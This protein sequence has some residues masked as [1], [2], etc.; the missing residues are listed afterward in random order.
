MPKNQHNNPPHAEL[1]T[2]AEVRLQQQ[3]ISPA[4][5]KQD[6][7]EEMIRLIHELEVHHVELEMQQEELAHKRIEL[8]ESLDKYTELYDFAPT[9]YLT[10]GRDSTILQSNLTA[11]KLL[12]VD[13]SSLEGMQLKRFVVPGDYR[14]IEDLLETVFTKRVPRNCELKLL[15]VALQPSSNEYPAL[16]GRTLRLDAVISETSYMCKVILTDI[17]ER[18]YAETA[19]KNSEERFRVMFEKHSAIKLVIDPET[20]NI[21]NANQAAADIYGWSVEKLCTMKIQDINTLSP[22]QVKCEME[23]SR[24]SEKKQF[25]FQHRQA[26]GSILD[27]EV[28]SNPI[29]IEGKILLYSIIHDITDRKR[30]AEES[31]RLKSA[32]LANISHEIRTPMNGI[33]GFSELLKDADLTGEEQAEYIDL[34][35]QSGHRML[36]LINDLMDI[37]KIDAKET[38]LQLTQTPINNLLQQIE[39]SFRLE[40]KKGGLSLRCTTGLSDTESTITT[41]SVKLSL[42]MT[43]LIQNALKFTTKGGVDFGYTRKDDT[44]EFYCID[45]GIGIA[46]DHKEKIFDRFHQIDTS[47]TRNQEGSGLGLSIAKAYVEMLCGKLNVQSKEGA[48]SSFTFTLF[49]NP[50]NPPNPT[51]LS[52]KNFFCILVVEDDA[53]STHLMN[54]YLKYETITILNAENG[55]E[56]LELV[57]HHPEINLV[58]MDIKM[59]I[60]N[61]YEATKLI[62]QQ[63]PDLPVIAQSAFTTKEDKQK[64]QEAGCNAF[65]TKPINKTE[66]FN[67]IIQFRER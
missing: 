26:E 5:S 7:S 41:D 53:V 43:K 34:I 37:S 22:E 61:G 63:R 16:S 19:L 60:M 24:L 36:N 8:E 2:Q 6:S 40:A 57:Q 20:G 56:A 23:K 46:A 51:E 38:K 14:I 55:W 32:F 3:K 21:I 49:Y 62:K 52:T 17:T 31:D 42:I 54:K 66:L 47:L 27:V 44:L 29:E 64:A 4:L 33:I 25:V 39:A 35:E 48:G 45:S 18:K 58:L 50:I 28:F 10:L 30:A 11:A 65:I 67:F 9:G 12:E 15:P 1:R 59:P 13:R